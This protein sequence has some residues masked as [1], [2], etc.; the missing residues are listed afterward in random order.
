MSDVK[1][2]GAG[3]D[4]TAEV[5]NG[6][7]AAADYV[8]DGRYDLAQIALADA[9]LSATLAL[10]E[11]QERTAEQLRIGNLMALAQSRAEYAAKELRVQAGKALGL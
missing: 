3:I 6:Q 1:P 5:I 10:V 9:N 11:A 8:I 2:E 7:E 4:H